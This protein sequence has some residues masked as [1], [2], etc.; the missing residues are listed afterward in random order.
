MPPRAW[1]FS[2]YLLE[3]GSVSDRDTNARLAL[4]D[5]IK[6]ATPVHLWPFKWPFKMDENCDALGSAR[7][8]MPQG[9]AILR[10]STLTL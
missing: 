8:A 5:S 10:P 3:K 4:Q 7:W 1:Q 6:T 2:R 9:I